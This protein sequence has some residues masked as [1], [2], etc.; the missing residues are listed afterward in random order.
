M[1]FYKLVKIKKI[2]EIFIIKQEKNATQ[3]KKKLWHLIDMMHKQ[4][5]E[6]YSALQHILGW[7]K[8]IEF[9]P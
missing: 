7:W 3:L 2:F 9:F 6:K 4:K 5:Y 1:C 8:N